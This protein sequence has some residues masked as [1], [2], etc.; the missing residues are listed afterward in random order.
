M[1]VAESGEYVLTLKL[2]RDRCST[3]VNW[4]VKA[5]A[6]WRRNLIRRDDRRRRQVL[7]STC[8]ASWVIQDIRSDFRAALAEL[9]SEYNDIA[10]ALRSSPEI[11]AAPTSTLSCGSKARSLR[12]S[13]IIESKI[14]ALAL[15]TIG[16]C[17]SLGYGLCR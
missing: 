6:R 13:K 11:V 2:V 10:G 1:P 4:I 15:A 12:K 8:S 9:P 5:S 17:K 7:G 14:A 3:P 16:N